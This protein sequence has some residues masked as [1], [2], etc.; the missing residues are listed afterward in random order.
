MQTMQLRRIV[1]L[2]CLFTYAVKNNLTLV[3]ALGERLS[4]IIL[5][6]QREIA[7][8][9]VENNTERGGESVLSSPF[10]NSYFCISVP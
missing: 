1:W 4:M 7:L 8:R 9:S 2:F 5:E 3:L 6:F 10:N